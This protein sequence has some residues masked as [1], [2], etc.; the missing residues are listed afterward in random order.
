MITSS[1]PPLHS[2]PYIPYQSTRGLKLQLDFDVSPDV[3]VN[4]SHLPALVQDA[5]HR[6]ERCGVVL[7]IETIVRQI[8]GKLHRSMCVCVCACMCVC[9]CVN[10]CMRMYA[11]V[12]VCVYVCMCARAHVCTVIPAVAERSEGV[13]FRVFSFF[14]HFFIFL[15]IFPLIFFVFFMFSH[16]FSI[17]FVLSFFFQVFFFFVFFLR[18]FP[19]FFCFFVI[20]PPVPGP[21]STPKTSLFLTQILIKARFRVREEEER[22]RKNDERRKKKEEERRKKK[23]TKK[24]ERRTRRQ[25]QVPFHNRTHRTFFFSRAWKP[26]TPT[27]VLV[28]VC[29]CVCVYVC[30]CVRVYVC[31][32]MCMYENVFVYVYVWVN[33][34]HLLA[35]V[36]DAPHRLE[37]RGVVLLIETTVRHVN[38]KQH[39]R[40]Q[41]GG[42]SL[43]TKWLFYHDPDHTRCTTAH[44]S[45]RSPSCQSLAGPANNENR[46]E[47]GV[48]VCVCCKSSNHSQHQV[49]IFTI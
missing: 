32:C 22:R 31:T 6:F 3:N 20:S 33:G 49:T 47:N 18:F 38:G 8:N 39:R 1:P 44:S 37:R 21:S 28:Y 29:S 5:P 25:K 19:F 12:C 17:F 35:L 7:L 46:A 27:C 43:G 11:Y 23:K 9:V 40:S 24:E 2:G 10:V 16:F 42:A 4:G 13:P 30:T 15:K 26:L 34:S 41:D 48:C 45:Q 14:F 36:Q